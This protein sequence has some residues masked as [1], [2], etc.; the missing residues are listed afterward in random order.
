MD[1][2]WAAMVRMWARSLFRRGRVEEELARELRFHLEQEAAEARARGVPEK[3][4][5]SEARRR[6]GGVTQIQEECRD[7]RKAKPIEEFEQDTR[8]AA[9]VLAKSPGF[10]LTMLL[11]LAL[12]I[13]AVSAIVS[14]V[15]G[16]LLRP[17]PYREP[18]RLVRIFTSN[19]AWPKFP[20]NPNDFRD[21]RA[22]LRCF[23]SMAAYT[24]NDVPLAGSG[25]TVRLSGFAVTG[26]FFHVL[27]LKPAIGR[28]FDQNDE[29]PAKGNIAIVSDRMWRSRLGG[30]RDAIGRKIVL[31]AVPY[32]VVG[33]M[34]R[35]VEHPGNMYH[36][37]AYGETV[38]VWTPFTNYGDPKFRGAHYLD[39]I[40]RL[41]PGVTVAQA[42]GEMNAGMRQLAREHQGSEDGWNVIVNP[43]G[44]EIV[45][46]SERL[47]LV[48]LGA[49]GLVLL[50]GCVNSA[51]L[52]LARATA[53]HR[54]MA[55]RTAMG[56]GRRR[57]IQQVL[58]ESV[59]LAMGGAAMGA[60]LAFAG[61]KILLKLLP[62][63]FPRSGDIHLDAPVFAFTLL[64][65]L[66]SGIVFGL[67]PALL[68]TKAEL[69]LSLHEG[70]RSSTSSRRTLRL[71]NGLVMS[72]VA[73]ACVLLIGTALMLSSFVHL[74]RSDPG[75]RPERVVTASISLPHL[76]YKDTKAVSVFYRQVLA[77]ISS[78]PG[79]EAVG[80]GSDLPWTGWDENN[81]GFFIKGEAPPPRQDFHA[82]YHVATPGYFRALGIPIVR[83]RAFD[84]GDEPGAPG[85]LIINEAMARYWKHG[86]ALGGKVSFEDN[87]KTGKDWLTVI[88]IAKDT[89]DTPQNAGAEPA[90]WWAVD[91]EPWPMAADASIAIRSEED[92]NRVADRLR[93]VA[94]EL[95]P[96]LAVA[97]VRT[98]EAIA[99]GSYATPRFAL[100]LVGAFALLALTLAAIGTY[101]VIAYSVNQRIPEF[102]VR[103]ALGAGPRDVLRDVMANG[104]KLGAAG[105]FAGVLLGVGFA[106]FL[107]NLLYGVKAA[108]PMVIAASCAIAMATASLASYVPALRA[109]RVDPMRALRAE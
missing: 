40:A 75:F 100:A 86:D 37:V 61:V 28:E 41:K 1:G 53:R 107:G 65:A 31:N 45:G 66:A 99:D 9:R 93:A 79:V 88:G 10:T 95:D 16:V 21:F 89:K 81:G 60:V 58:T 85:V 39:G 104:F 62:A 13:G 12:S 91:Q 87:P 23:E 105:T 49:A 35:G 108:D 42:E 106:R 82:R 59:L 76:N 2:R 96:T 77:Q 71:R 48:L 52:L 55:L 19:R 43:L 51:N 38:D 67:A 15:E 54:E 94:R 14:V 70:G 27:G 57:L 25:E 56:A 8:Y 7:M 44:Q 32:E 33:V 78:T 34:P 17:L 46:R 5:A 84:A 102:G 83:G 92:A 29:M 80:V 22:R 72:E 109:T 18:G 101:G 73:L 64:L 68:G 11:T 63:D 20:I 90:F 6:L 26:G 4:A 74:L 24:R 103:M 97:E 69:N 50:L 47:V 30:R 98:M 36:A 3:E